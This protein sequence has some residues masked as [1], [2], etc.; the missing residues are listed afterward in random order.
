MTLKYIAISSH[1]YFIFLE[2]IS[3]RKSWSK[4]GSGFKT[5][6]LWGIYQVYP[7]EEESEKN[8]L[9]NFAFWHKQLEET[10]RVGISA[11]VVR[12]F[13]ICR[14]PVRQASPKYNCWATLGSSQD[15]WLKIRIC[16][17]PWH[18]HEVIAPVTD[19]FWQSRIIALRLQL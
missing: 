19:A 10:V 2:S 15:W 18:R 13:G 6:V 14:T 9:A 5:T 8:A 3:A 16:F 4:W 12:Q 11:G 17:V 1:S 7:K